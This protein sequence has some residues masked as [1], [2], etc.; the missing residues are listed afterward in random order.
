ME[1]SLD[2]KIDNED[3]DLPRTQH[4]NNKVIDDDVQKIE[5]VRQGGITTAKATEN[6]VQ[7]CAN[8]TTD[9]GPENI[10]INGPNS[11]QPTF[12]TRRF[13]GSYKSEKIL[14]YQTKD[15]VQNNGDSPKTLQAAPISSISTRQHE[16][17]FCGRRYRYKGPLVEHILRVHCN[18]K[19][20]YCDICGKTFGTN[21]GVSVHR[22]IHSN[23]RPY[24]CTVCPKGFNSK[25]E[26]NEHMCV[27][28][29]N[30][31]YTCT[32]CGKNF[33]KKTKINAHMATHTGAYR[34]KCDVC[35]KGFN[36]RPRLLGHK[37]KQTNDPSNSEKQL[38]TNS[39]NDV[40]NLETASSIRPYECQF[41]GKQF[42]YKKNLNEHARIHSGERPFSCDICGMTFARYDSRMN[43]LSKHSGDY[44]YT[45]DVCGKGFN[46]GSSMTQHRRYHT[47]NGFIK[48]Y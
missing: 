38:A 21:S 39:Q 8:S 34:F 30:W 29:G 14:D 3:F 43:H 18:E 42:V 27:H 37:H 46:T 16:C 2:I 33:P 25:G 40:N 32:V 23:E 26:L 48:P 17:E 9:Y 35:G 44:R 4:S 28:T 1:L 24:K 15:G 10:N 11:E 5:S 31:P 47:D 19:P 6:E 7:N 13:N 45:C 12:V 22:N 36:N 41:C 20:F